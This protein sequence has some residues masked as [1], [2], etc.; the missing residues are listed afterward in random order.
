LSILVSE[1]T[2]IAL[3]SASAVFIRVSDLGVKI[4]V[5][6]SILTILVSELTIRVLSGGTCPFALP[7]AGPTV[8]DEL[9]ELAKLLI[10]NPTAST[11]AVLWISDSPLCNSPA[12]IMTLKEL[13]I[14]DTPDSLVLPE[15]ETVTSAL[16]E[17]VTVL[18]LV[19]VALTVTVLFISLVACSRSLRTALALTVDSLVTST[20]AL[21]ICRAAS[22]ETVTVLEILEMPCSR[23]LRTA[24]ALTVVVLSISLD[25]LARILGV[26]L[27]VVSALIED[28]PVNDFVAVALTVNSALMSLLALSYGKPC[29]VIL[30]SLDIELVALFICSLA[31]AE[32]VKLLDIFAMPCSRSLRT[33][34][35]LTVD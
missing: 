9:I 18:I 4:A 8:N 7:T 22:A 27:T 12:A 20:L 24:L 10:L 13:S 1:G 35:A 23:S 11:V 26:A 19:G 34:V 5:S 3:V 25:P 30:N 32:V 6:C 15:L 29:A 31:A 28:C 17:L 21:L 16:G 14:C 2:S 33:A